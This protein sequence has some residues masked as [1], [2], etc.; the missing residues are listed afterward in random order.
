M[1]T[2][3]VNHGA[4]LGTLLGF[5]CADLQGILIHV[6]C[7]SHP[8][9]KGVRLDLHQA[10]HDGFH[11][12]KDGV[13]WGDGARASRGHVALLNNQPGWSYL[14]GTGTCS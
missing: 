14:L 11:W 2:R 10:T 6:G 12:P 8:G 7:S 1:E 13:H 5:S 3:V 9:Q 4:D